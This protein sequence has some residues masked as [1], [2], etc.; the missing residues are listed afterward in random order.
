MTQQS[1]KVVLVTGASAGIGRAC[2][3]YLQRRGDRVYGT[4]RDWSTR[5]PAPFEMIAMDVTQDES[6]Q[7]AVDDLLTREGRIDAVVNNAGSGIAG[8]IEDTPVEEARAQ[9][10]ANFFGALRVCRAVLPA[11]RAQRHG[12]IVNMSSIA[13]LIGIPYEGMYSASKFA[14]EG[15]SE[16]LR[17]EVKPFGVRV[18]L[19]EPGDHH[20]EFTDQ[21][22]ALPAS[23]AYAKD[24]AAALAIMQKDERSGRAPETV[25]PLVA[26]I[27]DH[28]SPRLRYR[29][30]KLL[31]QAAVTLKVIL[32]P[33]LA[34]RLLMNHYGLG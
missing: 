5:S 2:A 24:F 27:I 12:T 26:R 14:L 32:P 11:M 3:E 31:D 17:M 15:M 23:E 28:P 10:E 9:F 21:R 13:G 34:E 19:V 33:K 16:V 30:G 22:R 6:V 29:T 20:T 1:N 7:R 4:S 18:V 8:A 25:A